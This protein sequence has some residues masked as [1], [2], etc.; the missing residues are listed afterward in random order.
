LNTTPFATTVIATDLTINHILEY[1]LSII[2]SIG[3]PVKLCCV[4]S[5]I[6]SAILS[7]FIAYILPVIVHAQMLSS[8]VDSPVYIPHPGCT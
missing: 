4:C 7:A 2:H 6:L 1:L 3:F 8:C 5:V